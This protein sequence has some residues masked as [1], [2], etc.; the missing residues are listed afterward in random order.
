[1]LHEQAEVTNLRYRLGDIAA[2]QADDADTR[3]RLAGVEVGHAPRAGYVAAIAR[4]TVAGVVESRLPGLRGKVRWQ[5]A[6]QIRVS[7][8]G[9]RHSAES[10]ISVAR[11]HLREQLEQDFEEVELHV[12]NE[13]DDFVTP[14]GD[15]E[16][17]PRLPRR[18]PLKRMCVWIDVYWQGERIRTIPAWFAVRAWRRALVLD[19]PV[20]ARE[21]LTGV[22][23]SVRR[24]DAAALAG[25]PVEPGLDRGAFWTRRDLPQGHVLVDSDLA[26][27][28]EVRA[29]ERV[30]AHVRSGAIDLV[31]V[32][33][34]QADGY[35]GDRVPVLNPRSGENFFARVKALNEVEVREN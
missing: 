11:S 21:V 13:P 29:G 10:F 8:R 22:A 18:R 26:L 17:V 32:G 33:L 6:E 16:F 28:P 30:R 7:S 5:G 9:V 24:V 31:I 34:A 20:S 1:M 35:E 19:S 3:V 27:R 14:E 23:A 15:L 12:A 2:I 25:V 4:E